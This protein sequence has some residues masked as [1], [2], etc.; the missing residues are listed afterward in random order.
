MSIKK[1]VWAVDLNDEPSGRRNALF[2]LGALAR[3]TDA[4]IE[5]VF[6]SSPASAEFAELYEKRLLEV[7]RT[8]DIPKLTSGKFLV[9]GSSS[10]RAQIQ[11]LIQHSV[12]I[13]ADLVVVATHARAGLSRFFVGSFAETLLLNSPIPLM[14]VNP[15]TQVREKISSILFPCTFQPQFRTEFAMVVELAQ[16]LDAKL[17]LFYKEPVQTDAYLGPEMYEAIARES[18]ARELVAKKWQLW[19]GEQDVST[20]LHLDNQP[21]YFIQTLVDLAAE[22]NFDLIAMSTQADAVSNLL[23]GSSARQ[24]IREAPCPVW[25]VRSDRLA[26]D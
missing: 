1:I 20:S 12:A 9:A 15:G 18:K 8:S 23:I 25:I 22:A 24:V 14:T 5:A 11:C 3:L 19:A 7:T 17:T 16:A 2:V 10:V 6:V 21:G 4:A 13:H 26:K